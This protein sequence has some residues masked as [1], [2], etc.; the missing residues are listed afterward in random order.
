MNRL[1]LRSAVAALLLLAGAAAFAQPAP[2]CTPPPGDGSTANTTTCSISSSQAFVDTTSTVTVQTW[3]TRLLAVLDG[4]TTVYDQTFALAFGDPTVQAAVALAQAALTSAGA[5]DPVSVGAPSQ[6]SLT[7][8]LLSSITAA[9][10]V[11]DTVVTLI[12]TAEVAVGPATILVGDRDAGGVP[13]FVRGGE[14]NTNLNVETHTDVFRNIVT[15]NTFLTTAVYAITGTTQRPTDVPE[16]HSL[17]LVLLALA[18]LAL[19]N[20]RSFRA[21]GRPREQF[22]A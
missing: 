18:G 16:P 20:R 15:T 5:P 8:G 22:A 19:A 6:T 14:V 11:T 1:T 17:S 10:V 13:Y 2:V 3:S 21:S 4:G 7:T 9:P 12:A